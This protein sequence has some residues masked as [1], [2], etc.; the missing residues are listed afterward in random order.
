[1]NDDTRP[2]MRALG[3]LTSFE[4][5]DAISAD[6]IL[7][8][9]IGAQEQHGPHLPL[10]TDTIIA[11]QFTALLAQEHGQRFDIWQLPA[12]QYGLSLEHSWAP[13][14][15]SL[16]IT[17]LRSLLEAVIT[18]HLRSTDARRILIVN[19][20][21]GNRGLLEPFLRELEHDHGVTG[22]IIHPIA[23]S[24][25]AANDGS[26]P[27]IHAG[28]TETAI[29]LALAA[30]DVHLDR[31]PPHHAGASARIEEFVLN[32]GT[33]W[34]WSTAD[35]ALARVGV[36]GGDPRKATATMGKAVLGSA[37][38]AAERALD[39]LTT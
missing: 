33:T 16:R 9:P 10:N 29:M 11:E 7:C 36:I 4:I 12:I 26:T 28:I 22:C 27:E 19:G 17:S 23:L 8:L 15:I 21:G 5:S 6:S 38:H 39:N 25:I 3:R 24:T 14:T 30:Q 31:I 34:P 20:H 18:E 37:L 35:D 32:R 1:M 2:A 13:G